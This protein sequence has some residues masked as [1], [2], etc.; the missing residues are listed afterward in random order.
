MSHL[1]PVHITDKN[2]KQ[3]TVRKNLRSTTG[4]STPDFPVPSTQPKMTRAQQQAEKQQIRD[5]IYEMA[6]EPGT[7]GP[8]GPDAITKKLKSLKDLPQLKRTLEVALAIKGNKMPERDQGHEWWIFAR[9]IKTELME[10]GHRN[11]EA[12]HKGTNDKDG[13]AAITKLHT[14]LASRVK[15][16]FGAPPVVI[17]RMDNHIFAYETLR[18]SA[19]YGSDS[20]NWG[21]YA[22]NYAPLV[23]RYPDHC[24]QLCSYLMERGGAAGF[25]EDGFAQYLQA[26]PAIAEGAL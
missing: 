24:E 10:I 8:S 25:D 7:Y 22:D 6:V 26:S 15:Q 16:R 23:A 19:S 12:I 21:N 9:D 3:T 13:Y 4:S 5:A 1:T 14:H 2:G 11:L 17:D 20:S 18:R